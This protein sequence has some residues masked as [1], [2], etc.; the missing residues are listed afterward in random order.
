[1][2]RWTLN[3]GV[4]R[5]PQAF[6]ITDREMICRYFVMIISSTISLNDDSQVDEMQSS[7]QPCPAKFGCVT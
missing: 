7:A 3:D 6:A 2:K 4:S 1:M 5:I